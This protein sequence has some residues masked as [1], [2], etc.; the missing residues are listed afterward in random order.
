MSNTRAEKE[1]QKK[2]EEIAAQL[3]DLE[4]AIGAHQKEADNGR[5]VWGHVGDL[6]YVADDLAGLL[7]FLGVYE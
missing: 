1:Y 2:Q 6:A 3:K 4:R 5:D 7:V